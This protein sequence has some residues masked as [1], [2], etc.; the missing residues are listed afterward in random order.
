MAGSNEIPARA[1]PIPQDFPPV[2]Y[3]PCVEPVSDASRAR[4]AM[5]T[6]R[7]A[8]VA[9]LAYSALDRLHNCCGR[10]QPWVLMPTTSLDGL[11]QAQ[12]FQLLLLDVV[13]PSDKRQTGP[14]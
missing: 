3:L 5:R 14:A 1:T 4:I 10:S 9:L 13:I 11:Q 7:D 12:P 8:R 2:L 6:T